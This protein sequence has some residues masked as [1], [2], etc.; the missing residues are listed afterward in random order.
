MVVANIS[1]HLDLLS[2]VMRYLRSQKAK[3]QSEC[4][5]TSGLLD[6]E[7]SCSLALQAC[8]AMAV[9]QSQSAC[10]ELEQLKVTYLFMQ[11]CKLNGLR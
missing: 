10:A 4:P 2:G 1:Q 7:W 6:K 8:A 5:V 3:H 9:S 11:A